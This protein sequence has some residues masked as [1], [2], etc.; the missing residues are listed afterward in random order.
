MACFHHSIKSGKKGSAA[1]HAAYISRKGKHNRREDLVATGHGN[2]PE[3]ASSNPSVF[4]KAGDK[5]ERT[6]GAVY[7]EHEIALP[8]E[9]T[10][11]Q[12]LELVEEYIDQIVADKPYEFAIHKSNSSIQGATNPHLHLM[13]SDRL[14]DGIDRKPEK[15][16]KRYN[17]KQPENGGC[18]KDSGG[19]SLVEL[20]E[21]IIKTRKLSADLQN[22]ALERYGHSSRVDHRSL[23]EQGIVRPPERHLGP[24]RIQAMTREQKENI[25][26][27]RGNCI[28]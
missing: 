2:M 21:E 17:A 7:R 26:K 4:W 9:L 20:R 11:E 19:K 6:N 16:F 22:A 12:T 10:S 15:L 14:H 1:E 23:K 27:A 5:H 3:W 18:K 28:S 24:A 8:S 25:V 13:F